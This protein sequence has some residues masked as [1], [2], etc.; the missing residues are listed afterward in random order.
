LIGGL[1][2]GVMQRGL[3]FRE[4]IETFSM[5]TVGDGLEAQIPAL[6]I[7]VA[8]AGR[9][10]GAWGPV[11]IGTLPP[12]RDQTGDPGRHLP[13]PANAQSHGRDSDRSPRPVGGQP[14]PG[15][16]AGCVR[17]TTA[18]IRLLYQVISRRKKTMRCLHTLA[19]AA[20]LLG[21]CAQI[22]SVP[23]SEFVTVPVAITDRHGITEC[24][25]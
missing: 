5:L 7:S 25:R 8:A 12:R 23:S 18:A 4:A 24:T 6:P 11:H 16:F 13:C 21:G 2:V 17:P 20:F 3:P 1:A 22:P 19:L 10:P 14:S 9:N 15:C